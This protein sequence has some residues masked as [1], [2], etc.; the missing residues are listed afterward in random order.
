MKAVL[1]LGEL[2]IDFVPE[3]NGQA[4][5]DVGSFRRAPGGAPANVAAAVARLGGRARFIGKTGTDAFGD[6]LIQTLADVGVD[7]SFLTRTAEVKTGLAFVSLKEDGE[8][9]FLFYRD[10][11]ADMLLERNDITDELFAEAAVFHFGS[12]SL[13]ADPARSAT[14]YA[15][16]QARKHGLLVSYDP[17]VRLALW[18]GAEDARRTILSY[19]PLAD[20]VKVS[21]EELEFLTGTVDVREGTASWFTQGVRL[22][23]ITRGKQGSTYVLPDGSTGDVPGIPAQAVDATG[24]GDAFVGAVLYQLAERMTCNPGDVLGGLN[25]EVLVRLLTFANVAGA[26]ATEQR[27]AIPAL[28][29]MAVV[30]KALDD[31]REKR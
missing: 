13:I 15:A 29:H 12:L 4:L 18:P 16:E 26:L 28:P 7:T 30:N 17:N 19:M 24:A 9:D 5:A 25:H 31:L 2:L 20:V 22:V 8:R 27:G 3:T 14:V 21:E 1:S 11:A 23:L 6:F 10:P